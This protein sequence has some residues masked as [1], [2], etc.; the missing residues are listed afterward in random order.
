LSTEKENAMSDL[1][2]PVRRREPGAHGT[3]GKSDFAP[4]AQRDHLRRDQHFAH[5]TNPDDGGPDPFG[6]GGFAGGGDQSQSGYGV[7]FGQLD[8]ASQH[9]RH[10]SERDYRRAGTGLKSER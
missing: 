10:P 3:Y 4:S 5:R 8:A 9:E 7:D 2:P 6:A 1:Q